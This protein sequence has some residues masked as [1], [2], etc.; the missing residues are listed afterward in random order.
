[1]GEAARILIIEDDD[2]VRRILR[3]MLEDEGYIVDVARNGKEAINKSNMTFYNIA[4]IDILLPDMKGTQLLKAIKKTMPEMGKIVITGFPS[5][6]NAIEAVNSGADSFLLKPF[7]GEEL[8]KTV[9]ALLEKQE[10]AKKYSQEQVAEF[11]ET[12]VREL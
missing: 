5:L 1:M 10:K 4:L 7:Q 9:R 11:I 12:R 3:I 2:D 8:L 6:E